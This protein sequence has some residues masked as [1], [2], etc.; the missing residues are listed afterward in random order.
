MGWNTSLLVAEGQSLEQMKALLPDY[1]TITDTTV[2]FERAASGSLWPSVA[3]GECSG[4]GVLFTPNEGLILCKMLE[5]ASRSSGALALTLNSVKTYYA[6]YLFARGR[7]QR[8]LIRQDR[9]FV[10]EAGRPLA[11]ETGLV[12]EDEE[13]T[14]FE[15]AYCVTGLRLAH[16]DTWSGAR[17]VLA[18]LDL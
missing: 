2:N 7:Q 8:K 4:W 17:F 16:W 9:R 18:T 5:A 13:D 6:L 1:F 14:L 12:W 10:E 3:L 15:L 11:E